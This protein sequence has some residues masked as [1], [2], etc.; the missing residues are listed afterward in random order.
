MATGRLRIPPLGTVPGLKNVHNK[1]I[2]VFIYPLELKGLGQFT[3]KYKDD[4][5]N[6]DAGF[7]YLPAFKRTIRVSATTY[8]D[9][10]GGSDFTY[11]DPEGLRE[12]YGTWNFKLIAKKLMLIAEPV[13]ER[14]PVLKDLF[15]DPQ[16]EFKEGEKYP[17]LGWT[18]NPVYIV[19]AT[20]KDKGHVYSKKIIYVEDPYFSSALTEEMATVDI[21]DR[22]G[23]LWKCFYNWRGGIFHHKDGNVYTTT[24]GYTIHDL[25]TGHTTHFPNLCLGLNTGMQEDFLSLKR[26]LILGR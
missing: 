10:V 2:N 16:V 11:G 14:Q 22:T 21:Y 26:L 5:V 23:T 20:P 13:A 24:N 4:A 12:P 9:N 7:A 15:V 8:Q 18:I 17:L 1:F 6:Y 19:E 25:Q 3:I